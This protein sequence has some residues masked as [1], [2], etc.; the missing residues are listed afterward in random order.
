M[1]LR[2]RAEIYFMCTLNLGDNSYRKGKDLNGRRE[3][4]TFHRWSSQ[5]RLAKTAD[6]LWCGLELNMRMSWA[7]KVSAP[8]VPRAIH[9]R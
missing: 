3:I 5:T 2:L 4:Q 1:E 9:A 6:C 8:C 7:W